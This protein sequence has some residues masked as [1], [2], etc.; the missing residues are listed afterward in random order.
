MALVNLIEINLTSNTASLTSTY[1]SN[2]VETIAYT[3]SSNNISFAPRSEIS[4]SGADFNVLVSQ[5]N[6]LATAII[7]NFN[8]PV[9][10]TT[11]FNSFNSSEVF[12]SFTNSQSLICNENGGSDI[13]SYY[14]TQ[15][16][17]IVSL[18][19]RPSTIT[20]PLTEWI[21]LITSLNHYNNDIIN[22]L[23]A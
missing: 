4:I 1:L 17:G 6:I 2:V 13:V 5:V 20:I 11:P 15:S 14:G 16:T 8:P 7:A 12:I 19:N 23:A 9:T 3:Q 10:N 18:L 22:L 21:M